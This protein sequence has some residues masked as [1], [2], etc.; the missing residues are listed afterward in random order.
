MEHFGIGLVLLP[1]ISAITIISGADF[2]FIPL[3]ITLTLCSKDENLLHSFVA[4]FHSCMW[5]LHP[6]AQK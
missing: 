4:C 3:F 1:H 5:L 6:S 2:T